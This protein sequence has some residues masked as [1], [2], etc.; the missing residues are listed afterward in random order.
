VN[1]PRTGRTTYSLKHV[2]RSAP[3]ANLFKV[4]SDYTVTK[5]GG[6]GGDER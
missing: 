5:A 3:D 1:D 4:P 6:R 2:N